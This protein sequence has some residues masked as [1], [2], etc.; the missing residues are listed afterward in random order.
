MAAIHSFV[1]VTSCASSAAA[2]PCEGL[3][4]LGAA[5][6]ASSRRQHASA[7]DGWTRS[8]MFM[9]HLPIGRREK[10]STHTADTLMAGMGRKRTQAVTLA[11]CLRML[12]RVR[13][14]AIGRNLGGPGRWRVRWTCLGDRRSARS[15]L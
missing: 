2:A 4:V 3:E 11:T 13:E 10:L 8:R 1:L 6:E 5:G 15:A 9:W 7:D 14:R 12:N